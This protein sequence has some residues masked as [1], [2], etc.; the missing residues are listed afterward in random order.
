MIGA[1]GRSPLAP[2]LIMALALL[3]AAPDARAEA[4][5]SA[6]TRDVQR[7]VLGGSG[8][9]TKCRSWIMFRSC[10][11]YD[12]ISLPVETAVGDQFRIAFGS[13]IKY[14]YFP[15][16]RIVE[17]GGTCTLFGEAGTDLARLDHIVTPCHVLEPS[18]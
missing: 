5:A 6:T 16:V 14:Y 3:A 11:S 2:G 12:D 10:N 8:V 4:A 13:N 15:V 17:A 7:V 18:D 9:L 1:R